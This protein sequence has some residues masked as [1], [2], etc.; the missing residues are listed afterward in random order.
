[1]TQEYKKAVQN[2]ISSED[3]FELEFEY[4]A[5]DLYSGIKENLISKIRK[6]TTDLG[7]PSLAGPI[8]TI[9]YELAVNG[10][11]ALYKK[12]FFSYL[13]QDIG[14]GDISYKDWLGIFKAEIDSNKAINFS[15]VCREHNLTLKISG[16]KNNE[17]LRFEVVNDGHLSDIEK[18]RLIS[19]VKKSK[20]LNSF[21]D[22]IGDEDSPEN[23]SNEEEQ[24]GLGIPLIIMTL[25]G[26]GLSLANF[27]V[28]LKKKTTTSRLDIP[29]DLFHGTKGQS[30]KIYKENHNESAI[31]QNIYKK[32]GYSLIEFNLNGEIQSITGPI[33]D[34]LNIPESEIDSFPVAIKA[35][36]FEDIF[37]GPFSIKSVNQF[38]NYRISIPFKDNSD[39]IMFNVSGILE[40]SN[41]VHTLW[42]AV[43]IAG[44]KKGA[45]SEGS[46]IENVHLQ[47]LISPYIPEMILDKARQS[48][49]MGKNTLPNEVKDV[50]IFFGDLIGFTT[51]SESLAHDKVIDLLNIA[52]GTVVHSVEQHQGNIDKFMGDGIMVIFLEP[53]SAVIAAIEIQNN[54]FQLNEFREASG[55]MP[56]NIRIGINSGSVILGSVGTKKRMDWTAL[57]D[58]VNTASRIEKSSEK[59]A[60]LI[61]EETYERIKDQVTFTEKI[62]RKVKGK[63]EEITL[64]YINS[65]SFVSKDRNITL[66]LQE[67]ELE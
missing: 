20:T 19:L 3:N 22:L 56:I 4:I 39:D 49:R 61:S 33:L 8:N 23:D 31:L 40:N 32:L 14:W 43:N 65:V 11:K 5:Y 6:I 62:K 45:L 57:G 66:S 24:S 64:Y 60:V 59:N 16:K 47:K 1:M 27:H 52:M 18:K 10:M 25:R 63:A 44:K 53:L 46:V 38:E 17:N 34:R 29:L 41:T 51:A 30:I 48:I 2:N 21:Y 15:R 67:E 55:Q 36:F 35:K 37:S 50:T 28:V 12:A 9:V 7:R 26:L 54:F 13:I 58:V 42:Q